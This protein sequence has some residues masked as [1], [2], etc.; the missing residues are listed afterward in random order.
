MRTRGDGT[1]Y[2][3][4]RTWRSHTHRGNVH[5]GVSPGCQW[6][7]QLMSLVLPPALP[8]V[9]VTSPAENHAASGR[10]CTGDGPNRSY[11][12][13]P[14]GG[15]MATQPCPYASPLVGAT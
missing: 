3:A 5:S 14:S 2:A 13:A 8:A 9:I 6:R 4:G 1:T 12:G 7:S 10:G 11:D 15:K